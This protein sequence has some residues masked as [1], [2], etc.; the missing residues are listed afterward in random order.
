MMLEAK[1]YG[2]AHVKKKQAKIWFKFQNMYWL[3]E[4]RSKL[5]IYDKET[6]Y[7]Q[8]LRTLQIY[9]ASYEVMQKN[10]TLI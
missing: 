10:T 6:L 4:R 9:G 7:K 5:S 3:L 1:L 2:E 8:V